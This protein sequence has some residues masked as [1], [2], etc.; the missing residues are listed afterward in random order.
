MS[1]LTTRVD[2]GT[3]MAAAPSTT[4]RRGRLARPTI[5]A[6]VIDSRPVDSGIEE[7]LSTLI[8]QVAEEHHNLIQ[9]FEEAVSTIQVG[10]AQY[11]AQ[12]QNAV[13]KETLEAIQQARGVGDRAA[14]FRR[15][16]GAIADDFVA[17]LANPAE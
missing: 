15:T 4:K 5:E 8:G 11:L 6:P 9:G 14:L 2:Q 3:G 16:A 13:T 7:T 12:R 17:S 10:T 1:D